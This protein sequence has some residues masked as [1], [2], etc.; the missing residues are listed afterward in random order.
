MSAWT[1]FAASHEAHREA[2]DAF[3]HLVTLHRAGA[4]VPLP[5]VEQ[6][7]DRLDASFRR[8]KTAAAVVVGQDCNADYSAL[9]AA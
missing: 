7:V 5:E 4:V 8:M 6:T 3:L 2:V 9:R 1:E